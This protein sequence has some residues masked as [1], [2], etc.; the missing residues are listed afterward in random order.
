MILG[1]EF[2]LPNCSHY[3]TEISDDYKYSMQ[4]LRQAHLSCTI[5]FVVAGFMKAGSSYLY[6]LLTSH[7]Q[8]VKLLRGVAFKESGCYLPDSMRGKK[9]PARMN[10]FPFIEQGEMFIYGDATVNYA[11]RKEVPKFLHQDNPNI[12]VSIVNTFLSA[13]AII[14]IVQV[15]NCDVSN[16]INCAG[17]I[18]HQGSHC[19]HIV[20]P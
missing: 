10:C 9:S 8:I 5:S 17:H 18:H 3:S 7:P 2:K 1:C 4:E 12:K 19:A 16:F 6:N 14:I 13:N 20:S 11:V 15:N